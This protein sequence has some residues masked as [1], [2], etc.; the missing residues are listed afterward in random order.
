MTLIYQPCVHW[1]PQN[2]SKNQQL[3]QHN[4]QPHTLHNIL[5]SDTFLAFKQA[6]GYSY[7]FNK[8]RTQ[9][10]QLPQRQEESDVSYEAFEDNS[11]HMKDG[12]F[13]HDDFFLKYFCEK[14]L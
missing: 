4:R 10:Q 3:R 8:I 13:T 7:T 12:S 5:I 6:E 9:C 14:I 1:E 2:S 11:K